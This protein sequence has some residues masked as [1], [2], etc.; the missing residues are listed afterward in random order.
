MRAPLTKTQKEVFDFVV[1]FEG[2]EDRFPSIREISAGRVGDR[3]VI[4][5]RSTST[6]HF[7]VS[8]LTDKKWLEADQWENRTFWRVAP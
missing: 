5:R 1:A 4:R 8:R 7:L 3:E 6:V 2:A